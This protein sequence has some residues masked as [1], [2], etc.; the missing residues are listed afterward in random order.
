MSFYAAEANKN[1]PSAEYS[2]IG[3]KNMKWEVEFP[4]SLALGGIRWSMPNKSQ[5]EPACYC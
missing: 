5:Y 1:I 2:L 3:Y 4:K